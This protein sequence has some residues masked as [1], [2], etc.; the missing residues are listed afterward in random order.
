MAN[1][2]HGRRVSAILASGMRRREFIAVLSSAA[3]AWSLDSFA[4]Q[5]DGLRR[6]GVL[7]PFAES[8]E[9]AQTRL[10]AFEE[11]FQKLGWVS[12]RNVQIERRW[13][14]GNPDR[15]RVLAKELVDLKPDVILAHSTP[16]VAALQQETRTVPIVFA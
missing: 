8:D 11:T 2:V 13:A 7:I 3:A 10:R 1:R 12:G 14:G 15:I 9:E 4:Q 6:I 16:A 5:S